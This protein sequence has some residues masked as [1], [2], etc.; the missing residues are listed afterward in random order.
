[1]KKSHTASAWESPTVF[2]GEGSLEGGKSLS[3]QQ[4]TQPCQGGP[5]AHLEIRRAAECWVGDGRAQGLSPKTLRDRRDMMARF[6][7]WLVHEE[8][9][10]PVLGNMDPLRIRAFLTYCRTPHPTG[11]F[12]TDR[13]RS[14]KEA[15][16][17][18]INDYFRILR[19]FVNFSLAEGFLSVS[20]L[21]NMKAPKVPREQVE[22]FSKDQLQA[23][24]D[25]ARRGTSP[26]RDLAML[27]ALLDSGMRVSEMAGL[28]MKDVEVATGRMAVLGKGNKRRAVFLGQVGRRLLRRYLEAHRRE[29]A[30][31]EPVFV[32]LR[33]PRAGQGLG[34]NGIY[35]IVQKLGWHAGLAGQKCNPHRFRHTFC[36]NFLR[37]GG[38][39][40]QLQELMGHTDLTI[41][42]RYCAIAEC[43]LEQAHRKSSPGD[44][45][46]LR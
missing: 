27:L 1:M 13:D 2:G 17:A 33:G 29:S 30:P 31:G 40:Y 18:T 42:R 4:P 14:R 6:C 11:R 26:E 16:P 32:S 15:R 22:P 23:L 37:A 41:L 5:Y 46:R 38:N 43:D 3:Q 45:L 44:N 19:G 36:I 28:R 9:A 8:R 25:A 20:P 34:A 7:W 21:A 35:Q 10:E 24:L 39:L 12:G